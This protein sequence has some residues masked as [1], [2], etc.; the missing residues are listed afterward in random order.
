MTQQSAA[1]HRAAASR[2]HHVLRTFGYGVL[3]LTVAMT[4]FVCY[5]YRTLNANLN[6]VDLNGLLTNRPAKVNTGPKGPLNILVMGSDSRDGKGNNI[7][8]L[9][10]DGQRSDTTII[11][12]LSADRKHAY[13]VSLPRDAMV[14]RP[15]CKKRNGDTIPGG[16]AM[17]NAAFSYGGPTC[18]VQQ[19]EQL[20]G[21]RIDDFVV[22]DFSGFKDMVDA[23]HGVRICV[24]ED[25]DDTVGNIHLK[26]GTRTVKGREALD[27][28]RVRHG[29]SA[30]GDIGRMKRQQ[31]F[32]ASMINKVMSAGTLANPVRLINFLK[33]ATKSLTVDKGLGNLKKIAD[34]GL[35]FKGIS[36]DDIKFITVPFTSY[37]PDPNR[38]VWTS[39]ADKL[40]R[41][42]RNDQPLSKK[43]SSDAVSAGDEG[44]KSDKGGKGK[45]S[46]SSSPSSSPG[47]DSTADDATHEEIARENG[48]C[49]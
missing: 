21:I 2:Q 17:F 35:Q 30:N 34:L 18:T 41:K 49:A 32:I 15:D 28:V 3:T 39:D 26:A 16:F 11:V 22:V 45:P 5:T 4:L 20:T 44:S 10:N 47:A 42:I 27:Y 13:G 24:P 6:V 9:T 7:D 31:V 33:A 12:H 43:L 19:V 48:L 14:Q 1:R 8:G 38:L 37:E 40:W 29:I 46:S 23:V 25:V 36:L